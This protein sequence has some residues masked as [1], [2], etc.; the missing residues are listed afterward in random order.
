MPLRPSC[1]FEYYHSSSV[2]MDG[3]ILS[4]NKS[5][6]IFRADEMA[7]GKSRMEEFP[8]DMDKDSTSAVF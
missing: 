5:G 3:V 7:S 2:F 4:E 1:A 8:G 6:G